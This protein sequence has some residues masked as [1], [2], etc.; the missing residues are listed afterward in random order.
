MNW[1]KCLNIIVLLSSISCIHAQDN[2]EYVIAGFAVEGNKTTKE[3]LILRECGYLKGETIPPNEM[4]KTLSN[5]KDNITN[6]QLFSTVSVTPVPL[7]GGKV[8]I[9]IDVAER[10]YLYPLPVVQLAEPNFNVWWR[11]KKDSRTNY[12][13]KFRQYNFRGRNERLAA[14]FKLG[15]SREFKLEWSTP[16]LIRDKNWGIG[17]AA[18]YKEGEEITTGTFDNVREFYRGTDARTRIEERYSLAATNRPNIFLQHSFHLFYENV[19]VTDSVRILHPDHL[20]YGNARMRHLGLSYNMSLTRLDRKGYPRRGH[21]L[22]FSV[23]KTGL[24]VVSDGADIL[25]MRGNARKFFTLSKRWNTGHS[26][27]VR[28]THYNYLPYYSQRGLGY[29]GNSVRSY[30]FYIQ[31]GQHY[32]LARNNLAFNLLPEKILP[33]LGLLENTFPEV[34]MAIFVNLIADVGYVK[35]RLYAKNN[36]LNNE[37]LL[38]TGLGL[39]LVTNYDIV[40]RAEYTVN[41]LGEH[42]FFLHYRRS[43]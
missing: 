24:G 36:P 7:P 21:A 37:L 41:K 26:V 5:L 14:S 18:R 27:S 6:L 17:V 15:Y 25:V 23:T 8:L 20:T 40:F 3:W 29:G 38:G 32:V 31:D 39:D 30:E 19:Q 13:M 35:D 16:Y 2:T 11:N 33:N 42:G 10:W 34:G 28:S 4:E 43:I 9:L 12:G 22:S 1:L